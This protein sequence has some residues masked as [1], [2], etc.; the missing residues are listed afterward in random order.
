MSKATSQ[1]MSQGM[2]EGTAVS[3]AAGVGTGVRI[4]ALT[5]HPIES[6]G[7]RYR[8]I[9]FFPELRRMGFQI[10][11]ESFFDS[12][13]Y[14]SLYKPGMLPKLRALVAGTARRAK[15]LVRARNYDLIWIHLWLHPITFPPFDVAIRALDVPVVYDFDDAYYDVGSVTNRLRDRNWAPRLMR[16]AHTVVTG[17]EYIR[18]FIQPHNSNVEILPTSIDTER[19]R[20]RDFDR[21][22]NPRP[23]IGW[24]GSQ[25][26]APYLEQVVYPVIQR[27]AADHDFVF[28]VIG[29]GGATPLPGVNVEYLPWRLENEVSNF[30]QLDIGLYPLHDNE[31]TRGKHGFKLNQYRAVGVPAVVSAVG[32]NPSIIRNG[33]NGYIATTPEE[34]YAALRSL[35]RDESLRRRIGLACVQEVEAK[36]SVHSVG[37]QLAEI[38]KN[39]A[40]SRHTTDRGGHFT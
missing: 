1:G 21:E 34:W 10:D 28:R 12:V 9:Q 38:L 40:A 29:A 32:L 5:G 13:E 20:P 30:Q 15:D 7:A 2:S 22:R 3:P 33:E 39:A 6:A 18:A 36:A 11:H 8:L 25:H 26:T 4:L 27:L 19:F 23:V 37:S 35:L 14:S 16:R 17:S 31:L 24:V